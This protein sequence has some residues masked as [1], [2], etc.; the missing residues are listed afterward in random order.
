MMQHRHKNATTVV[1]RSAYARMRRHP[2]YLQSWG[3]DEVRLEPYAALLP[4]DLL[5]E[6]V[7]EEDFR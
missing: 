6:L 5:Q 1:C 2:R 4:L 7:P 3:W